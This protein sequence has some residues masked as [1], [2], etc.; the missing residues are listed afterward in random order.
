[1]LATAMPD[2]Q[3]DEK[4]RIVGVL[5]QD[6]LAAQRYT[7]DY[8]RRT[9]TWD[10]GAPVAGIVLTMRRTA[11]GTFLVDLPQEGRARFLSR[12]AGPRRWCSSSAAPRRRPWRCGRRRT[13]G[14]KTLAS[15]PP[16]EPAGSP[17]CAPG[18]FAG[19]A[20]KDN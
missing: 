12:T 9:V 16:R 10:A 6:V 13:V 1:M 20:S 17:T 7:I 3:F 18:P 15:A 4:G 19:T 11:Y 14:V 8:E 5:G 2:G